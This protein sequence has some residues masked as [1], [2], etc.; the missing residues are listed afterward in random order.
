MHIKYM[1]IGFT[2]AKAEEWGHPV[3]EESL[4]RQA[5]EKCYQYRKKN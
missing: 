2:M 1:Y 4:V 5:N 3:T